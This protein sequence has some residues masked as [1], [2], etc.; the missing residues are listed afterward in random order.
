MLDRVFIVQDLGWN[1]AGRLD[2]GKDPGD[3]GKKQ[4]MVGAEVKQKMHP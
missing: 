2:Y 4:K 3:R 1:N